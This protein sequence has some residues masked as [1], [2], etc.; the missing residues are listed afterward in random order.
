MFCKYKSDHA[1]KI[2]SEYRIKKKLCLTESFK[3][4]IENLWPSKHSNYILSQYMNK[5]SNNEYFAPVKFKEKISQMNN[6]FQG[7]QA[8]D[9][10]DLVNF[11]IMTLHQELNK[12]PQKKDLNESNLSIDQSKRD[13]VLSNF[14]QGFY[15]E[16][17]SLISDI[18]Y[19]VNDNCSKCSHCNITK[20]NFQVYF[21]L[22]FPLE[23][24]RKFKIQEEINKFMITNQN[25]MKINPVLYQQN[26]F[27][28]QNQCQCINSVNIYDCFRYNQKIDYFLNQNAMYCNI[29]RGQF[30]SSYQALLYTTPEILIIILNRGTGI[31]FKVKCEFTLNLNLF[32]FVE[33]KDSGY[34]FD[35]ICVVTHMGENGASGHFIAYCKNPIDQDWYL[36][37]DDLVFIVKDFKKEVID[38]AMPYILFYQKKP[39]N[40]SA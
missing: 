28:F 10:K 12:A 17:Q 19:A 4:L 26:L 35:L 40:A 25:L 14:I 13:L 6:L 8:N 23:E 22:N 39:N 34:I 29:C 5:N 32:D 16:N 15:N 38:Y 37:N 31:Q 11:L 18:F 20:Y 21:F 36:Y 24:V 2:I 3:Y 27:V 7:V 30:D 1:L 33:M 9:A